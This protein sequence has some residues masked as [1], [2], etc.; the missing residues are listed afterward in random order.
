MKKPNMD[1]FLH[2]VGIVVA[3]GGLVSAIFATDDS[4]ELKDQLKD[5]QKRIDN[6]EKNGG[7]S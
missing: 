1:K 2:V 5:M 3:A 4:K 7:R 6:L